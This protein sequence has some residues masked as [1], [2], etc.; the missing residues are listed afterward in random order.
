[1]QPVLMQFRVR[2]HFRCYRNSSLNNVSRRKACK[3]SPRDII[4]RVRSKPSCIFHV[5]MRINGLPHRPS[6]YTIFPIVTFSL[7]T[8]FFPLLFKFFP[9]LFFPF[10]SFPSLPPYFNFTSHNKT[11][12]NLWEEKKEKKKNEFIYLHFSQIVTKSKPRRI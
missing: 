3:S 5:V 7:A 6:N 9:F 1:M 2:I 10:P 12:R 4:D 11:R 8:I